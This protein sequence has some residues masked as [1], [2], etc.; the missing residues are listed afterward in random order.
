M[1]SSGFND[2]SWLDGTGRPRTEKLTLYNAYAEW[3]L[4]I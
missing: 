3:I 1:D 2:Q 4:A